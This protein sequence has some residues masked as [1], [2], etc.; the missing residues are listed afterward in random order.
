MNFGSVFFYGVIRM[1]ILPQEKK[2]K[3]ILLPF[4]HEYLPK[5][6]Q[7]A[8]FFVHEYSIIIPLDI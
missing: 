4:F 8:Y 6:I 2:T 5:Y 1:L 3:Y 7:S